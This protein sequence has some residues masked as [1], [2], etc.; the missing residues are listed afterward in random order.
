MASRMVTLLIVGFQSLISKLRKT[1]YNSSDMNGSYR[2]DLFVSTAIIVGSLVAAVVGVYFLQS[3]LRAQVS[4]VAEMNQRIQAYFDNVGL[5]A[6]LKQSAPQ[7]NK[8]LEVMNRLIPDHD[9]LFGL[10]DWIDTVSRNHRVVSSFNFAGEPPIPSPG[11][12]GQI[13]FTLTLSGNVEDLTSFLQE[14]E[15][16]A[17]AQYLLT[18][19]T[20]TVS[21]NSGTYQVTIQGKAYFQ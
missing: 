4:H 11:T 12:I 19:D 14:I 16:L 9:H 3:A 17:T 1:L 6:S 8:Y 10:R 2:R 15:S 20:F 18:F 7:A 21:R 13:G 5:V